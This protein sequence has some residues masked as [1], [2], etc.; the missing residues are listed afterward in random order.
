MW[1]GYIDTRMSYSPILL[2][3]RDF[4]AYHRDHVFV[5]HLQQADKTG[6]QAS[7]PAM[8]Y[9]RAELQTSPPHYPMEEWHNVRFAHMVYL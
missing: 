7:P 5:S 3:N 2:N 6:T 1:M 9:S 4:L 8:T